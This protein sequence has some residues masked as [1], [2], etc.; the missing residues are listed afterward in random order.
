MLVACYSEVTEYA[1]S[2]DLQGT[3]EN[4]ESKVSPSMEEVFP[5]P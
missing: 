4:I 3:D 5:K 2:M 1:H